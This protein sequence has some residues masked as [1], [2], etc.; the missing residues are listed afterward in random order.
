M[1]ASGQR[2]SGSAG[3]QAGSQG[4]GG[5]TGGQV[6]RA[7]GG[8]AYVWQPPA[9]R[10]RQAA[11]LLGSRLG[12][13]RAWLTQARCFLLPSGKGKVST[14]QASPGRTRARLPMGRA[15]ARRF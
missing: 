8:T 1:G 7:L 2:Q 3:R 9:I 13:N 4:Q 11:P 15:R 14:G 12:R 5:Q 6:A 10:T